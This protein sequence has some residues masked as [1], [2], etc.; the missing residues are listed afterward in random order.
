LLDQDVLAIDSW[1]IRLAVS[2]L[3]KNWGGSKRKSER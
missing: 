1:R 3:S 2:F